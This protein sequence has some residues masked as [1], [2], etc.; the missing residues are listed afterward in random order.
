MNDKISRNSENPW[1][2]LLN[3]INNTRSTQSFDPSDLLISKYSK[4]LNESGGKT[5][6]IG[7]Q[8]A[9]YEIDYKFDRFIVKIHLD[10]DG[11]FLGISEI[12]VNKN[13][14]NR[15]Q[16]LKSVN[17]DDFSQYYKDGE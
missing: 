16:K 4:L 5:G 14:L 9:V 3:Y 2:N 12:K 8:E 13:F 6:D 15:E 1:L 11:K 7:R 10:R 17:D